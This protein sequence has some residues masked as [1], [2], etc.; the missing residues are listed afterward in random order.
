MNWFH[1]SGLVKPEMSPLEKAILASLLDTPLKWIFSSVESDR[2]I[3]T[4]A[5]RNLDKGTVIITTV[6]EMA[7][8]MAWCEQLEFGS[9]FAAAW[10]QEAAGRIRN[11]KLIETEKLARLVEE[12]LLGIFVVR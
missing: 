3:G 11:R 5:C 1:R 4:L 6:S 7:G 9:A 12:R 2:G 10:Y 8:P